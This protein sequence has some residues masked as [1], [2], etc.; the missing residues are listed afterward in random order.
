MAGSS[1][2]LKPHDVRF[3]TDVLPTSA[4]TDAGTMT[5][6]AREQR[7][8]ALEC[9]PTKR[10]A[11]ADCDQVECVCDTLGGPEISG[12]QLSAANWSSASDPFAWR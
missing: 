10:G 4:G 9:W 5:N 2:R 12:A 11:A 8:D 3:L 6:Q 1:T 7:R